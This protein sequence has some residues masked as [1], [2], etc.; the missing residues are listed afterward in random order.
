[1]IKTNLKTRC[2]NYDFKTLLEKK[3]YAYFTRGNYNLNI[4]GVRSN[5]NK[6]VTNK[7]DDVLVVIYK[8]NNDVVVRKCFEITTKP[9]LYY[10]NNPAN[11]KGTGILV[12]NQYRGCWE[13]GFHQGKYKAL[14]QRKPVTVY[15][16]NNRDSVYD[17]EPNNTDT[18][19]FG[20]NIHKAGTNSTQVDKWSA[21][22]QVFANSS[23]FATFMKLCDN[24][25]SNGNGKT[26][27]YTLLNEEDL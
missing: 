19:I 8:D 6:R 10:M 21:A 2:A 9:G 15:R 12:P 16:D 18:G 26:F 1:M 11:N 23:D 13:I 4:I 25:I 22:C 7:F 27:T 24:Q 20:V 3:G 5:T 17:L 14:C